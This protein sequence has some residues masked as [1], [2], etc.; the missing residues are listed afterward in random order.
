MST[1]VIDSMCELLSFL[2]RE[3]V[4]KPDAVTVHVRDGSHGKVIELKVSD[5]DMGKII[6]RKGR[7]INSLR[8]L[9]C[10]LAHHHS[11]KI[12]LRVLE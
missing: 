4:D 10:A 9:I 11:I 7:I 6:G 12:S 3:L 1:A 8:E 5:S 2:A